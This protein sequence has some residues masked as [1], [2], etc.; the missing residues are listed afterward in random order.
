MRI[1]RPGWETAAAALLTALPLALCADGRE[2]AVTPQAELERLG[3]PTIEDANNYSENTRV[4]IRLRYPAGHARAG[5][6]VR[7]HAAPVRI[8]E[9]N[10]QVYDGL[11]GASHLPLEVRA[12]A[13]EVEIVLKSLARYVHF[14]Q[15]NM[16]IPQI[17]VYAGGEPQF[18]QIP[19]WVDA[20]GNDKT[21]WLE[22]RVDDLLRDARASPEPEVARAAAVLEGW[23]QSYKRDCGGFDEHRPRSITVSAACMDFDGEDSH[24]VNRGFELT[25]TVLHELW[26]A[27]SH[28]R[29]TG[30]LRKRRWP[31][32]PALHVEPIPCPNVCNG[33]VWLADPRYE[34]EEDDAETFAERYKHLFP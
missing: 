12:P 21:D 19:Q 23:E 34:A 14:D 2:S 25:A 28:A 8:E 20:D 16:P 15:R 29:S 30:D 22:H 4:R 5:R 32:T 6:L 11:Y 24:R 26:H 7:G 18:L 1:R 31:K 27:W 9:W 17:A 33:P 3:E 13:G 10:T